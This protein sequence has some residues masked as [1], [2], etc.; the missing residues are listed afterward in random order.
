MLIFFIVIRPLT[1]KYL[2]IMELFNEVTLL[3][4]SYYLF[5]FTSFVPDVEF[6][7]FLGWIFIGIV[8][9]NIIVNWGVL[10]YK[11]FSLIINKIRTFIKNR[12]LKQ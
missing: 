5:C 12:R 10:M 6:R 1:M 2:N 9:L 4:C 3:I 11:V 8:A 7:Y